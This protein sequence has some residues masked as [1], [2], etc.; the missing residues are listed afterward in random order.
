MASTKAP[1]IE[2]IRGGFPYPQLTPINGEPT[3]QSIDQLETECIRNASTV[4]CRLPAPHINLCGYIE[5][6]AN[7]L[8]RVGAA[9]PQ[10]QYPGNVPIFPN[11]CSQTV[12]NNT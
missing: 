5:Q 12:R 1:T 11:C 4:E 7:Y 2:D 10:E 8:L 3:F 9:F 6:L